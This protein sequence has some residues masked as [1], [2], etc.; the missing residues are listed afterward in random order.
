[1]Y[2]SLA[3]SRWLKKH[4]AHVL[5]AHIIHNVCIRQSAG[6]GYE[7]NSLRISRMLPEFQAVHN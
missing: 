3:F 7:T 1:M 6:S 2:V 4:A 5:K